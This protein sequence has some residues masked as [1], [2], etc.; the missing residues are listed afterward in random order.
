VDTE[1]SVQELTPLMGYWVTVITTDI[2]YVIAA[3]T[4]VEILTHNLTM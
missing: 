3:S 2:E 1:S 4:S